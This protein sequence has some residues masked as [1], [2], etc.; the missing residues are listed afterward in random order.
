MDNPAATQPPPAVAAYHA[1]QS[2]LLALVLDGKYQTAEYE[3]AQAE[4]R[5]VWERLDDDQRED[6]RAATLKAAEL[7]GEARE[8]TPADEPKERR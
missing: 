3:M 7:T 5:G 1:A 4:L 8:L 2:K 6:V